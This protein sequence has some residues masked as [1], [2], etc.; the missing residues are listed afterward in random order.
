MSYLLFSDYCFADTFQPTCRNDEVILMEQALYGR[1]Q[2]G[3]CI[4]ADFNIGCSSNE[5]QSFD[6][7]CSGQR[8]CEFAV[9]N[10]D[11]IRRL[12]CLQEMS[13]YLEASYKCIGGRC[14]L[15]NR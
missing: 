12:D 7:M 8:T 14:L 3:K 13:P 4:K 2:T 10:A 1:M 6:R 9:L 15:F 11:L 5:L